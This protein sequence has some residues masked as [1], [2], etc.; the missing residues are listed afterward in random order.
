MEKHFVI[1]YS[2]GTFMAETTERPVDSW[3]VEEATEMAH[4]VLQRHSAT[5]YAFRFVTRSRGDADL[6]SK[7][8]KQSPYYFLGGVVRTREEVEADNDPKEEIL[9]SNMRMND[10]KRIIT[11][12]NSWKWTQML[13]DDDVVLDFTPRTQAA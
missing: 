8:T 1:F 12:C 3:N 2:P 4:T 9:R 10:Y 11:N 6:D 7:V 5:P 13:N